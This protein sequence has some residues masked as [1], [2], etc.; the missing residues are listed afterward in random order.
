MRAFSLGLAAA[1][2][3][4]STETLNAERPML[5]QDFPDAERIGAGEAQ[6]AAGDELIPAVAIRLAHHSLERARMAVDVGDTQKAHG[7]A[8]ALDRSTGLQP[9]APHGNG[10]PW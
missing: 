1:I 8:A 5:D 9:R 4:G 3:L 2:L 6:V 7:A 10:R